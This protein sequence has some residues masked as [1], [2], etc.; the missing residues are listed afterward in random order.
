[1]Y[2]DNIIF[3]G[4]DT[5]KVSTE[6][7]YIEDQRG[8]KPVH[9]GKIKTNKSAIVKLSRQFQSKYPKAALHFVYEAGP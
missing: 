1:M 2:K 3:I 5:H 6:V 9:H 4:L 7:A 8:A